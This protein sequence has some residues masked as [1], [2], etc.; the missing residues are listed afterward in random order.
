MSVV[1]RV[2]PNTSE[3]RPLLGV[4]HVQESVQPV[5]FRRTGVF[6]GFFNRFN[7]CVN[8]N[9]GIDCLGHCSRR[10][11]L[12]MRRQ[13]LPLCFPYRSN[14]LFQLLNVLLGYGWTLALLA[15]G[16]LCFLF[17]CILAGLEEDKYKET[18]S[19]DLGS[20]R[21]NWILYLAVKI[22]LALYVSVIYGLNIARVNSIPG[23]HIFN[24]YINTTEDITDGMTNE[25]FALDVAR[26]TTVGIA[27]VDNDTS[28][29][30]FA[31][32]YSLTTIHVHV[33]NTAWRRNY[34]DPATNI[35]AAWWA[36]PSLV[37]AVTNLVLFL[38]LVKTKDFP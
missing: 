34:M 37:L 14:P 19:G 27:L 26:R 16:L 20:N 9:Y 3:S 30:A 10:M 33:Y 1:V 36:F 17:I 8:Y 13:P 32:R 12:P 38:V 2:D 28:M 31:Q 24:K 7:I 29:F 11:N 22:A 18:S 21:L 23:L 6:A 35:F 5:G 25:F 15:D 4:A